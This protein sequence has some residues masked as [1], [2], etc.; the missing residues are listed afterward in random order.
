MVT[1]QQSHGLRSD[2]LFLNTVLKHVLTLAHSD[3]GRTMLRTCLGTCTFHSP[4][5]M[6]SA[7]HVPEHVLGRLNEKC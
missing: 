3:D 5:F 7:V 2:G 4:I 6:G 1:P